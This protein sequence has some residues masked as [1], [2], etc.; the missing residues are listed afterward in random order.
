MLYKAIKMCR[1]DS[2]YHEQ[3]KLTVAQAAEILGIDRNMLVSIESLA[4][5]EKLIDRLRL[6]LLETGI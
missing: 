5:V 3:E 1:A 6:S 2:N 4:E